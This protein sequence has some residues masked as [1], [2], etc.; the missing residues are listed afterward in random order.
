MRMT[1]VVACATLGAGL[2]GG[3][4]LA[5]AW[6]ATREGQHSLQASVAESSPATQ[7]PERNTGRGETPSALK[8]LPASSP[9]PDCCDACERKLAALEA[10]IDARAEADAS[11][12][13]PMPDD[14]TNRQNPETIRAAVLQRLDDCE[15]EDVELLEVRCD[16]YPCLAALHYVDLDE[17]L[18]HDDCV[19]YD[20]RLFVPSSFAT[21]SLGPVGENQRDKTLLVGLAVYEEDVDSITGDRDAEHRRANDRASDLLSA[22]VEAVR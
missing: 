7:E 18:R 14:L 19:H 22:N 9:S 21:V 6:M 20:G 1:I 12:T 17:T 3:F 8:R 11:I 13:V 15:F 10:M 16:E 2:V 5:V 4:L